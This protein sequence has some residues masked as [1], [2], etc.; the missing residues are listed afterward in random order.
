MCED[1][2][3]SFSHPDVISITDPLTEVLRADARR[4]LAEAVKA[5]VD[6]RLP[7]QKEQ[8]LEAIRS[9]FAGWIGGPSDSGHARLFPPFWTVRGVN[10]STPLP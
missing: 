6:A 3:V 9:P 5:E 8:Q 1:T 10:L 4:L 7:R 2:V